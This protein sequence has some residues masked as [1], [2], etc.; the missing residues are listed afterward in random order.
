ME[1]KD[2]NQTNAAQAKLTYEQ[3]EQIAMKLQQRLVMTEN[4][5]RSIDFAAM[6]LGWLFKVLEQ[7]D[8]FSVEFANQ[9]ADEVEKILTI[10]DGVPSEDAPVELRHSEG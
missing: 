8:S 10:K 7:K 2:V 1:E 3:L 4:Q 6:R 9:C 5:L